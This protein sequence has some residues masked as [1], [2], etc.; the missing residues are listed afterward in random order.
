MMDDNDR[1][2]FAWGALAAL[3]WAA[4]F[5]MVWVAANVF[6]PSPFVA[7]VSTMLIMVLVGALIIWRVFDRTS[8]DGDGAIRPVAYTDLD[9]AHRIEFGT[10]IN[11]QYWN[12]QQG[13]N[14]STREVLIGN[15][16]VGEMRAN[17]EH[18]QGVVGPDG[19]LRLVLTADALRIV[20]MVARHVDAE[21]GT[22]YPDAARL[23]A[24][25]ADVETQQEE[26][27]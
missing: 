5:I 16:L 23:A 2:G 15:K 18:F 13:I 19:E 20:A 7:A 21:M 14:A 8:G 17:P 4:A 11:P 24:A 9:V 10:I 12:Q 6:A 27:R 26:R 3:T 1:N 22:V 25:R